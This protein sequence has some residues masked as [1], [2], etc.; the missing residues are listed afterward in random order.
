MNSERNNTDFPYNTNK[1]LSEY[2]YEKQDIL[3]YQQRLVYEYFV[4][5]KNRGILVFH[6]TG[7]GKT[8]IAVAIANKLKNN[9]KVI[10][11]S[12]KSLHNNFKNGIEQY[13]KLTE[14]KDTKNAEY[15]YI[16]SNASN[17]IKKVSESSKTEEDMHYEKTMEII[18][19]EIHLNNVLLIVDEAH[20]FFNSVVNGSKNASTMYNYIMNAKN[21]KLVFLTATPI[22]ND[23]FEL[24]PLFNM[25]AGEKIMP[26][27]YEMFCELFINFDTN[28]VKN[29]EI[30]KNLHKKCHYMSFKTHARSPELVIY[31]QNL[32]LCYTCSTQARQKEQQPCR[33][34]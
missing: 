31:Q 15:T 20:N 16:S 4:N 7:Y 25:L 22:I 24:V 12:S 34:K 23:P 33:F 13:N 26:T 10:I 14:N 6:G 27:D 21:L 18:D 11:L 3:Q 29:K 30:F 17:M 28:T 32:R 9:Y 2:K 8:M 19:R 1:K 5:T